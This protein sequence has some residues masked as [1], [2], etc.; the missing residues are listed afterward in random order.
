MTFELLPILAPWLTVYLVV[1]AVGALTAVA[2]L[3]WFATDN[4]RERVSR[5]ESISVYYRHLLVG[6]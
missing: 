4:R 3:V 5:H 1:A 6:H 2:A